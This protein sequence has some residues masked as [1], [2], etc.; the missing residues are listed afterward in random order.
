MAL[1]FRFVTF[2]TD[3]GLED[4]FVGVCHGVIKKIAP[5]VQIIDISHGIPPQD[6]AAGANVLGQAVPFMPPA[7]HLAVVDPGVGT[8]RRPVVIGTKDGPPLVGPDNGLLWLAAQKLGGVVQAHEITNSELFLR[9]PSN[10]FHGRDVFSPVAA[11][12]ALG[13]SPEQVGPAIPVDEL[14]TLEIPTARVDDDHVHG[15]V[16]QADHFG[17][18]QL[19]VHRADLEGAGI[20]LGDD[21]EIRVG[22]KAYGV[23]FREAFAEV[24][25]GRLALLEDS[26]R[27][28]TIVVNQGHAAKHLEARRGDPV[29]LARAP[30]QPAGA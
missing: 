9:I 29:I 16:V 8:H 20:M 14:V 25:Q 18:L 3:Y 11:R 2:L 17:N 7:V 5:D 12:L 15:Q 27:H 19:N 21:L 23:P 24:P 6:V 10:T 30:K 4:E 1:S 13:V 22:G 26:Y 28:I